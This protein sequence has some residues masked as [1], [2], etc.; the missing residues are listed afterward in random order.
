MSLKTDSASSDVHSR[1]WP[2]SNP[3][4]A[5]KDMTVA[6]GSMI[7][8][9]VSKTTNAFGS[10]W[11][12]IANGVNAAKDTA[13]GLATDP[14][15]S[16]VSLGKRAQPVWNMIPP[17]GQTALGAGA[18]W[19]IPAVHSIVP[20]VKLGGLS[21]LGWRH[22]PERVKETIQQF[23]PVA[24]AGL[25]LDDLKQLKE[26]P[27]IEFAGQNIN[28]RLPPAPDPR[29]PLSNIT[30]ASSKILQDAE[31]LGVRPEQI[32]DRPILSL[33][34]AMTP[35]Q[36][37]APSTPNIAGTAEAQA[38]DPI[39]SYH[40]SLRTVPASTGPKETIKTVDRKAKTDLE[41]DKL[42]KKLSDFSTL[43]V[44]AIDICHIDKK[45]YSSLLKLVSDAS[46]QDPD[47]NPPSLW[48]LFTTQYKPSFWQKIKAGLFY[49]W[50]H[51]VTSL[52]PNT[53][54]TYLKHFIHQVRKEI[55]GENSQKKSDERIPKIIEDG[56]KFLRALNGAADDF[57]KG[58]V[59]TFTS[60]DEYRTDRIAMHYGGSIWEA[61]NNKK[62]RDL[63]MALD[64][65]T[66]IYFEP[67]KPP[68]G[69]AR[70]GTTPLA[71]PYMKRA[72][73]ILSG[74]FC[75]KMMDAYSP[76]VE[77][78]KNW[79]SNSFGKY[80]NF[81]FIPI[82]GLLNWFLRWAMKSKILPPI[83]ADGIDQG[84]DATAKHNL[85]FSIALT[86]FFSEKLEELRQE[87]EKPGEREPS[88]TSLFPT[89]AVKHLGD[90][91]KEILVMLDQ[92]SINSKDDLQK[93][94][95]QPKTLN[96][97]FQQQLEEAITDNSKILFEYLAQPENAETLFCQL[98]ELASSAFSDS[99]VSTDDE[100]VKHRD[101]LKNDIQDL[102]EDAD[103]VF[104]KLLNKS[105]AEKV[106]GNQSE[107]A[108]KRADLKFRDQKQEAAEAFS[109]LHDLSQTM[110]SRIKA[111]DEKPENAAVPVNIHAEIASFAQIMKTFAHREKA[112]L[113]AE[114]LDDADREA[115]HRVLTPLYQKA[116]S[117]EGELA[118]LQ[119]F[120]E[121]HLN[122]A[123][124]NAESDELAKGIHSI[125]SFEPSPVKR[126][127]L[128]DAIESIRTKILDSYELESFVKALDAPSL[129]SVHIIN[130]S[131]QNLLDRY[132]DDK[133]ICKE[134]EALK[135]KYNSAVVYQFSL[136]T[137][138]QMRKSIAEIGKYL[139][140]SPE[141]AKELEENLNQ[142]TKTFDRLAIERQLL[143]EIDRLCPADGT[144]GLIENLVRYRRG[145]TLP[146][147]FT[148]KNCNGEIKRILS[149][150]K[151]ELFPEAHELLT[152]IDQARNPSSPDF[153][154]R[155]KRL[156]ALLKQTRISH[157]EHHRSLRRELNASL[158]SFNQTNEDHRRAYTLR[159]QEA[160]DEMRHK[161]D[162][163]E[164]Q[165]EQLKSETE[166][167][168][169]YPQFPLTESR[170]A[171]GAVAL[172]A[173]AAAV[174]GY[175]GGLT[176]A[177]VASATTASLLNRVAKRK[178]LNKYVD[179]D[180]KVIDPVASAGLAL[181][182]SL[183]VRPAVGYLGEALVD[184][185]SWAAGT[186]L[187]SSGLPSGLPL[188]DAGT[189]LTQGAILLGSG[190][191]GYKSG[192]AA[193]G[194]LVEA[195]GQDKFLPE[196]KRYFKTGF[197][198]LTGDQSKH[199]VHG[200]ITRFMTAAIESH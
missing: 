69:K 14:I 109:Q 134:L 126:F 26:N 123:K 27:S 110:L 9:C 124:V 1:A 152:A 4:T 101:Q 64:E 83:F 16:A 135:Q 45:D 156:G 155:W 172:T 99:K 53:V 71:M 30:K 72:R 35:H 118:S 164:Q 58:T 7:G 176:G 80:F 161:T 181:G 122:N 59:S 90:L 103:Q 2:I 6:A 104:E 144:P 167:V 46:T 15:G 136:E 183:A 92:A 121:K 142:L 163:I 88:K 138:V 169:K 44:M 130:E 89:P 70:P 117:I 47:G 149:S 25:L 157:E 195:V 38:A 108:K 91:V 74:E 166:A 127:E 106:K 54:E 84:I 60:L 145:E 24:E 198:F 40:V 76:H 187:S 189:K 98:F 185:V 192:A 21:Y 193:T 194:E 97:E 173:G 177:S 178:N 3:F 19:A 51:K 199:L 139:P 116:A 94:K 112:N 182:A 151:P 143:M 162:F 147:G 115:M 50:C 39:P 196:V 120:Q 65:A 56:I 174:G 11:N 18:L 197:K 184:A 114:G 95:L 62:G 141:V 154:A 168:Q 29:I 119:K 66:E 146:R 28:G 57:D 87:I 190:Y 93:R 96:P 188:V 79:K 175:F 34:A 67:G 132:A 86:K 78:F 102:E 81:I 111:P 165:L 61:L 32:D 113:Q 107:K 49:F 125:V 5:I 42:C 10:V 23:R 150:F 20:F 158:Q 73:R 186:A 140:D 17:I 37:S 13:Y 63:D 137:R 160:R 153:P 43:K 36:T 191:M 148:I 180:F 171:R 48:Q 100:Y 77:F 22:M 170:I 41:L 8:G 75:R 179:K 105:V 12:G 133:E 52:I 31:K 82:D 68:K 200:A 159:K 55:S 131:F 129:R 33:P 128:L 85:P